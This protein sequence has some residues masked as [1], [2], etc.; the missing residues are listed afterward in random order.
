M[1]FKSYDFNMPI[2]DNRDEI[3]LIKVYG[4]LKNGG[5][6]LVAAMVGTDVEKWGHKYPGLFEILKLGNPRKVYEYTSH[7]TIP[8]LMVDMRKPRD[9]LPKEEIF[10]DLSVIM[11]YVKPQVG[12]VTSLEIGIRHM[13]EFPF[14][15]SL[16]VSDL[17]EP[18]DSYKRYLAGIFEGSEQRIFVLPGTLKELLDKREE[19]TTIFTDDADDVMSYLEY[20]EGIGKPEKLNEKQFFIFANPSWVKNDKGEVS[21]KYSEYFNECNERFKCNVTWINSHYIDLNDTSPGI[22]Y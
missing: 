18:T 12:S 9:P 8:S 10:R 6:C 3:I 16:Y 22:A 15:K 4:G 7:F 19:I 14:L 13:L 21:L 1:S 2:T 20:Y 11:S 5:E 17:V